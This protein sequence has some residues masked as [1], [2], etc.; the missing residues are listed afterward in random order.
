MHFGS[1]V[2]KKL[3]NTGTNPL[4][5]TNRGI[6]AN[7]KSC[8]NGKIYYG[9]LQFTWHYVDTMQW[10]SLNSKCASNH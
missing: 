3:H 2:M 8:F 4:F 7:E 1:F 6:W 10:P 9:I 5:T